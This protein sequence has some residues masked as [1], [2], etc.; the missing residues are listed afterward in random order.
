MTEPDFTDEDLMDGAGDAALYV[1]FSSEEASAEGREYTPLPTGSYKCII[2]D[3]QLTES[4][5]VKNPGK[6]MYNIRF[7]VIEDHK[8]GEFV[9]QKIFGTFCL[10]SGALYSMTML[11]K[12][13]GFAVNQGRMR[14]PTAEQLMGKEVVVSGVLAGP[15]KDKEDPTKEYAARFEAKGFLPT[16][17]WRAK[18]GNTVAA[19]RSGG[20]SNLL[21]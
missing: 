19:N 13:T 18:G 8:N 14:I 6:P 16:T 17:K 20:T 7:N 11:M 12:S 21:S 4:K 9:G 2:E 3:V 15:R 1:D 5:S 10:W